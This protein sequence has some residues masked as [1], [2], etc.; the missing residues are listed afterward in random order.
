MKHQIQGKKNSR[1]LLI[2]ITV[3]IGIGFIG[4]SVLMIAGYSHDVQDQAGDIGVFRS[5]ETSANLRA[6]IVAY[7]EV[8]QKIAYKIVDPAPENK[9]DF[10]SRLKQLREDEHFSELMFVRYFKDGVEYDF[11]GKE[12]ETT[13]ESQ[14]VLELGKKSELSCAGIVYD[15]YYDIAAVPIIV[16]LV[17]SEYADSAVVF[18]PVLTIFS[19]VN[20]SDESDF[21]NSRLSLFCALDGETISLLKSEG[22]SISVHNNVY[23]FLHEITSDKDAIDNIRQSI[24]DGASTAFPVIIEGENCVISVSS[25]KDGVADPFAAISV[26]RTSDIRDGGYMLIT[27]ILGTL[28]LFLTLIVIIVVFAIARRSDREKKRRDETEINKTL[29]VPTLVKFEHDASDIISRNKG[30]N[31]AIIM[32]EVR[33]FDYLRDRISQS[34][35]MRLLVYLKLIF[36]H[37]LQLDELL[38]YVNDSQFL[39]LLHYRD[40]DTIAQKLKTVSSVAMSYTGKLPVGFKLNLYGGIYQTE[41]NITNDVSKMI[42]FAEEAKDAINMPVDFGNF[43]LYNDKMHENAENTEYIETHMDRALENNEFWIF[44]QPTQNLKTKNIEGC[45]ALVRWYN[46]EKDEYM[47]PNVFMPLFEANRF[48]IKLD[49]F[50]YESVCKYIRDSVANR[51]AVYPVSVNVSSITAMEPDFVTYYSDLKRKYGISNGFITLEFPES[52]ANEENKML[53]DIM[54]ALHKNG[55]RCTVDD[56]GSG[57]SPYNILKELP[58]D[59]IKLS[60][61]FLKRGLSSDRDVKILAG[62][63]TMAKDLNMKI[64]QKNVET[65]EEATMLANLGCNAIQGYYYSKPLRMS[66]YIDFIDRS[67]HTID[68]YT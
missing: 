25:I 30:T 56:F 26:Y 32:I 9:D 12:Y 10:L 38:G 40:L 46:K 50:V 45:E 21:S 4:G 5:R 28:I 51:Q 7:K 6:S 36:S 52:L 17:S 2:V 64:S 18:V 8:V 35:T 63:I 37:I 15:K 24:I 42:D 34:D 57:Y 59:E 39:I 65:E 54:N 55:F 43:R 53:L 60:G 19:F 22:F 3:I 68:M 47:R 14:V 1:I 62:V 48:I 41:R 44:F 58:M 16:P 31:F 27:S 33:H 67:R 13:M 49:K 20:N 11:G 61:L 66:D 23:D 29:E